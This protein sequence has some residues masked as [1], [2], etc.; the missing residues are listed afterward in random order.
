M[1]IQG[2]YDF[3]ERTSQRIGRTMSRYVKGTR[4]PS[5]GRSPPWTG[6][7]WTFLIPRWTTSEPRSRPSGLAAPSMCTASSRQPRKA[8]PAIRSDPPL[9]P[10]VSGCKAARNTMCEPTRR[11]NIRRRSMS[12]S[13][14]GDAP[15]AL[16]GP[17]SPLIGLRCGRVQ[18]QEDDLGE[19]FADRQIEGVG[20]GIERAERE[21]PG[22]ARI[23][24]AERRDD[25]PARPGGPKPDLARDM[26]P[27]TNRLAGA[28]REPGPGRNP[29]LWRALLRGRDDHLIDGNVVSVRRQIARIEGI[30]RDF[31]LSEI[32]QHVGI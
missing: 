13:F 31:A 16:I 5:S 6:S 3:F 2:R 15:L 20:R 25:A 4:T 27:E 29:I 1:R 19:A 30:D 9:E 32:L 7:S 24:H 18:R 23:D 28:H 22:E 10:R 26:T 17:G 8:K 21:G 11:R 14:E 12:R